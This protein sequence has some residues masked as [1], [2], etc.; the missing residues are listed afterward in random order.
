[1]DKVLILRDCCL[2]DWMMATPLLR[3]LE[4]AHPGVRIDLAVGPFAEGLL[5]GHP[6]V[7]GILPYPKLWRRGERSLVESLTALRTMRAEGYDATFCLDI[8]FQPSLLAWL[9]GAPR[10]YGY[11]FGGKPVL[12]THTVERRVDDRYEA[13]AHLALVA[14]AGVEDQGLAL[15]F[16]VDTE[17]RE[18]ARAHLGDAGLE[19]GAC[20]LLLPGGGR[21][22]GTTMPE[23]RWPAARFGTLAR[24]LEEEHD[25][26]VGVLGGPGDREVCR[27]AVEA[28][29]G[30]A[31]D[32]GTSASFAESAAL[33]EQARMVIAND[34]F[35]M[36]LAAAVGAPLV[37]LFGPTDPEMVAPRGKRVEVARSPVAP[38]YRQILG[39]FDRAAAA[40]AMEALSVEAVREAAETLLDRTA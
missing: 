27:A 1:M 24:A 36:H 18:M 32:L 31:V 25:L 9:T 11:A 39:T 2:G 29:Q 26:G 19:P 8:G 23:K 37:A 28:A 30:A 17:D 14:L 4:V 21:N 40:D 12:H 10:R 34:S 7:D 22:P 16:P 15:E 13:E 20:V 33:L 6:R 35:G 38:S 5:R 3:A